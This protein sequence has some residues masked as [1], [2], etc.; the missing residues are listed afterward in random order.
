MKQLKH[1]HSHSI[2]LLDDST[3]YVIVKDYQPTLF[4]PYGNS[5]PNNWDSLS[6][7]KSYYEVDP[8]DNPDY[9]SLAHQIYLKEY[10]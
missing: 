5:K 3:I 7:T 10:N 9:F 6:D 2:D 4:Y 1:I 8:T